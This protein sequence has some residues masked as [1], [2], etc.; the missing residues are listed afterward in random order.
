MP[1]NQ[2]F[3][4]ADASP[5]VAPHFSTQTN[6]EHRVALP[7]PKGQKLLWVDDSGALLSLYKAVFENLGFAV[8]ATSSPGEA[9]SDASLGTAD[10]AILDYDMPEM[11]GAKLAR[12]IKGR[13]PHLPVILYSGSNS[14]PHSANRCVDAICSKGAPR[15]EL[16]AMIERLS[17][18]AGKSQKSG[19][20]LS[21]APSSNR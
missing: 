16:L 3:A 4:T 10:V 17:C 13:H 5:S 9:L 1:Y 18:R 14:I 8:T 2:W 7:P 19:Y 21:F 20:P 12:L 11:D 6:S 15:A